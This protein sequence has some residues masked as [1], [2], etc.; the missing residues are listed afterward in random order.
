MNPTEA[1]TRRWTLVLTCV[2]GF[3]TALDMLV[4]ATAL[5]AVARQLHADAASLGWT[6]N[7]YQIAL[8]AGIVTASTL[9][10][11]LGRRR[12]FAAGVALFTAASAA[13]AL[14]PSVGF[15]VGARTIQGIGAAIVSPLSLTLLAS[16]FPRRR[17]AVVGVWGG[18]AG[19]AI[20]AG[21]LVGGTLTQAL[22]WQ[23]IFWVN[24]PIGAA[25]TLLA[26]LRLGE[27]RGPDARLDLPGLALVTAGATALIWGLVRAGQ[28]GWASRPALAALAGGGLLLAA[29]LAWEVRAPQAMLP[30]HLFRSRTFGAANAAAFLMAAALIPAGLLLSQY[31]QFVL[32]STPL[33]AGLRFLPMTAAPLLVAPVAGSLSDRLGQRPVMLAGLVLMGLGLAWLTLVATT[34][35]SYGQLVAPLVL[36]GVGVSMPFA[37]TA[38]AALSAVG[39]ADVG[40][41]SGAVNTLRTFGGAFG[42]AVATAVF[43]AHGHLGAAASFDAGFRPAMAVTAGTALLG[44]AA[45]LGVGRR[46]AP[47]RAQAEPA[48]AP[49]AVAAD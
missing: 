4:V 39:P 40:R 18:V 24:V 29:F 13:C 33:Q 27:S 11:R 43:A 31:L 21:P 35:A 12:T 45:A 6:V 17:G 36:A 15:L 7:A 34:G 32:G 48:R 46:L 23:L 16:A 8:A 3:M 25:V 49:A 37:T 38:A 41:A 26:V 28:V 20:A 30:L 47:A 14:A 10:D 2:A 22:G 1:R 19:L 44:A 5:P 42:V 9:G